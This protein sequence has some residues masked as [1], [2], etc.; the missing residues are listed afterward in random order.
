MR[1]Y[2]RYLGLGFLPLLL[3]LPHLPYYDVIKGVVFFICVGVFWLAGFL[4]GVKE[5]IGAFL[6]KRARVSMGDFWG[7]SPLG[8][9]LSGIGKISGAVLIMWSFGDGAI[10]DIEIAMVGGCIL[11]MGAGWAIESRLEPNSKVPL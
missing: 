4:W 1:L 5:L 3:V 11:V 8:Q 7:Y 9:L 6:L 2:L 10:K